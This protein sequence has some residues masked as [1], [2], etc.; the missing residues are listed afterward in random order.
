MFV[1]GGTIAAFGII[2]VLWIGLIL[3]AVAGGSDVIGGVFRVAI[4]QRST[5]D[6]LQGRLGGLFFAAAVSGNRLGDAESGLAASVGGPQFAVWSG[7]VACIIGTA[8]MAW[9]IPQLWRKDRPTEGNR[10]ISRP[11]VKPVDIADPVTLPD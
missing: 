4:L 2:P 11:T 3:L 7:G 8:L 9:R 5:P 1:W 10:V 6:H